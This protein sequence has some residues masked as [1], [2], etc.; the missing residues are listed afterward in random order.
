[1]RNYKKQH[2]SGH[3]PEEFNGSGADRKL[4]CLGRVWEDICG[5]IKNSIS[6][7]TP[8]RNLMGAERTGNCSAWGGCGRTYAEL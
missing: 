3:T 6:P 5:T 4:L 8:Q 1:M 2:K 7:D